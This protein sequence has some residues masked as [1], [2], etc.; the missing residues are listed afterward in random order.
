MK[1]P[2][3]LRTEQ[4]HLDYFS[5]RLRHWQKKRSLS[6]FNIYCQFGDDELSMS[7]EDREEAYIGGHDLHACTA[8]CEFKRIAYG[9]AV[10]RISP[11]ADPRYYDALACHE[12]G[13][14]RY[15]EA[16]RL[17]S[18]LDEAAAEIVGMRLHTAID[19]DSMAMTGLKPTTTGTFKLPA[20]PWMPADFR[21]EDHY[22]QFHL[23]TH[24]QLVS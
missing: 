14:V 6:D 7:Q 20:P 10:I 24:R 9:E 16:E 1:K 5:S 18:K 13:H 21:V 11:Y 22:L 19:R 2:P 15:W 3:T 4:E 8:L 12:L 17:I 23:T